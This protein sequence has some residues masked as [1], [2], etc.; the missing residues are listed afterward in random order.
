MHVQ[1][2]WSVLFLSKALSKDQHSI[3]Y[4]RNASGFEDG[5]QMSIMMAA[6]AGVVIMKTRAA[7]S[8]G[9]VRWRYWLRISAFLGQISRRSSLPGDTVSQP[10][11]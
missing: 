5:L 7:K 2:V 9:H 11:K 8:I 3:S 1:V 6:S 10:D 4:S